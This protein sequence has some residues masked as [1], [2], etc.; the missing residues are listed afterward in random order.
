M[1][2]LKAKKIAT[3]KKIEEL[4][5]APCEYPL[6]DDEGNMK[7][8]GKKQMM[9][10]TIPIVQRLENGQLEYSESAAI[11]VPF[12]DYHCY[13][14]MSGMFG[15]EMSDKGGQLHGAFD[16]VH[17]IESVLFAQILSGK[18]QADLKASEDAKV[19]QKSL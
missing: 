8:C 7:K 6:L 2:Q 17:M 19:K 1:E 13:I 16:M 12:C 9:T 4:M 3:E 5:H 10:V 14:A 11:G 18:L 15:I